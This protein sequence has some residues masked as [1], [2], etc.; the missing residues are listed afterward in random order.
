MTDTVSF[1][2]V[3]S[4]SQGKVRFYATLNAV[5]ADGNTTG[6]IPNNT[7]AEFDEAGV[8]VPAVSQSALRVYPNPASTELR[9]PLTAGQGADISIVNALGQNVVR[10]SVTTNMVGEAIVSVREL[11]AGRYYVV[12]LQDGMLRYAPFVKN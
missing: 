8:G 4:T 7:M 1:N 2:W 5:N 10:Q 3:A 12:V 11:S 9:I 6:D